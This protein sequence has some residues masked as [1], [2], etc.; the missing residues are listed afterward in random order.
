[1]VCLCLHHLKSSRTP[2]TA[3]ISYSEVLGS[4]PALIIMTNVLL[5]HSF[6]NTSELLLFGLKIHVIGQDLMN[7]KKMA[8]F[9]VK[10]VLGPLG[11]GDILTGMFC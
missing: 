10:S 1:M 2:L 11:G 5:R 9:S 7:R 8:L 4:K 6:H 3:V